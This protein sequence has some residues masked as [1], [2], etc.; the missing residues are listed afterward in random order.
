[1]QQET[2]EQAS[3]R[4][5]LNS[6]MCL[7]RDFGLFPW[8]MCVAA[9]TIFGNNFAKQGRWIVAVVF[10]LAAIVSVLIIRHIIKIPI[11]VLPKPGESCAKCGPD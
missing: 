11:P 9:G 5:G 10:G 6:L 1:M 2:S 3:A 7:S 4:A 8:F